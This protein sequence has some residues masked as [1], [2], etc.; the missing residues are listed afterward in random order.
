MVEHENLCFKC[1]APNIKYNNAIIRKLIIIMS[2][3]C[4][5]TPEALGNNKVEGRLINSSVACRRHDVSI[6]KLFGIEEPRRL[7]YIVTIQYYTKK[8]KINS[9]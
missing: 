3:V 2:N 8:N 1:I 5:N 7:L 9:L 6:N 4:K